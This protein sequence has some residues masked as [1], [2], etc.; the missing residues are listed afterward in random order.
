M[1]EHFRLRVTRLR[2]CDVINSARQRQREERQ[3]I[4][5]ID[6]HR[7]RRGNE[8]IQ[9]QQLHEKMSSA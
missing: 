4:E 9:G 6:L 1:S 2:R 7:S 8:A 3:T 5:L